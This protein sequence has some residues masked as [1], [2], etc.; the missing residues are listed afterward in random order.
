[1]SVGLRSFIELVPWLATVIGA[2][3]LLLGLAMM[4]GR[5]VGLGAVGRLS[6]GSSETGGLAA[7]RGLR[8]VVR[9]RVAV[10]DKVTIAA[11]GSLV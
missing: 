9:D 6:P 5:R 10:A 2:G 11:S 7:S 1:V 3:L 4:A 8:R